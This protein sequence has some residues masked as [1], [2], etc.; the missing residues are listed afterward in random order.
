MENIEED[1]FEQIFENNTILCKIIHP[2]L[3]NKIFE[4]PLTIPQEVLISRINKLTKK[5]IENRQFIEFF[6]EINGK[7]I[8]FILFEI[9]FNSSLN[10]ELQNSILKLIH[11]L[12]FHIELNKEIFEYLFNKLSLIYRK[13][14]KPNPK[15]IQLIL[16]ILNELFFTSDEISLNPKNYFYFTGDGN[17]TIKPN[18]KNNKLIINYGITI[19][20]NFKVGLKVEEFNEDYTAQLLK[21]TFDSKEEFSINLKYPFVLTVDGINQ[22]PYRL[23]NHEDWNN[24]VINLGFDNKKKNCISIIVNGE[25]SINTHSFN[26]MFYNSSSEITNMVFFD[27]FVGET[28]S[29]IF[30]SQ[31]E[32]GVS[33]IFDNFFL[34]SFK[35]NYEG[36]WK[37]SRI[38]NFLKVINEQTSIKGKKTNDP[39]KIP[40]YLIDDLKFIITPFNCKKTIRPITKNSIN[41]IEDSLSNYNGYYN[42]IV[43][44]HQYQCYQ[45]KINLLFGIENLFPIA[46]MFLTISNLLNEENLKLYFSLFKKILKGRKKNLIIAHQNKCF[47]ILSLFFE[48]Y[49][50]HF[51]TKGLVEEISNIGKLLLIENQDELT[52]SYFENI[53]LNEKIIS[54]FSQDSQITLWDNI[55]LCLFSDSSE[56]GKIFNMKKMCIILRYYDERRYDKM[57]C[58]IHYSQFKEDYAGDK[59]IMNPTMPQRLLKMNKIFDFI[60]SNQ[61][62]ESVID[63][64]H[65]LTLDISPCLTKFILKVFIKAFEKDIFSEYQKKVSERQKQ[66]LEKNKNSNYELITSVEDLKKNVEEERKR[67]SL[68]I[69]NLESCN[70]YQILIG[71]FK[72]GLFDIRLDIIKLLFYIYINYINIT[73]NKPNNSF[74]EMLK[75]NLLPGEIFYITNKYLDKNEDEIKELAAHCTVKLNKNNSNHIKNNLCN[76]FN[77]KVCV[78]DEVELETY[79]VT[80]YN[81]LFF[82]TIK[83]YENIF[84]E[85]TIEQI[86][87]ENKIIY[88]PDILQLILYFCDELNKLD[89]TF[90]LIRKLSLLILC[91]NNNKI[92]LNNNSICFWLLDKMFE[93]FENKNELPKLIFKETENL[94]IKIFLN[95]LNKATN[96]ENPAIKLE[97]ILIWGSN[98]KNL[99]K[100]DTQIFNFIRFILYDIYERMY[101]IEGANIFEYKNKL[102]E[103]NIDTNSFLRNYL[104][105]TTLIFQFSYI[106]KY[107]NDDIRKNKDMYLEELSNQIFLPTLFQT[108]ISLNEET[109]GNNKDFL[110][111]D[112]IFFQSS[113][114]IFS[115]I[116]SKENMYKVNPSLLQNKSKD[117]FTKYE[118]ILSTIILNKEKKNYYMQD[119][120]FLCYNIEIDKN[121]L[122]MIPLLSIIPIQLMTI[123]SLLINGPEDEYLKYIKE[124]KRFIKFII[125]ASSNAFIKT[126][127]N[128]YNFIMDKCI[129]TISIGICFIEKISN[130]TIVKKEETKKCLT[131]LMALCLII[132]RHQ[133][134]YMEK[135]QFLKTILNKITRNNLSLCSVFKLFNTFIVDKENKPILDH[136][137]IRQLAPS[138]FSTIA[139]FLE[140]PELQN[141]FICNNKLKISLKTTYFYLEYLYNTSVTRINLKNQFFNKNQIDIEKDICNIIPDYVAEL[142]KYSNSSY[143]SQKEKKT[144]YQKLKK[145]MFSWNGLWSDKELFYKNANRLKLK[146]INHYTKNFMKPIL[147][148][149]LDLD[150][151]IPNFTHYDINF[152][153]TDDTM[154]NKKDKINLD[155]DQILKIDENSSNNNNNTE[156]NEKE[157]SPIDNYLRHIYKNSNVELAKNYLLISK[158]LD[159]GKDNDEYR[160]SNKNK[161][162]NKEEKNKNYYLCCIVKT[163][164]HIKGVISIESKNRYFQFKVFSNQKFE[165]KK[166]DYVFSIKG[167]DDY[168]PVRK[169][170]YGSFFPY[171]KKDKDLSHI[172]FNFITIKYIFRRRYFYK[173]S[174]LE[175]FTSNNKSYYFNFKK[176]KDRE[177]F[178]SELLES[179]SENC[180]IINDMK[181][182]DQF[183]NIIGYINNEIIKP[184]NRKKKLKLSKKVKEWSNWE[185]SNFELLMWLNILSNRSLNDISQYPIFPWILSNFTDPLQ[186]D[187]EEGINKDYLYR[188]LSLPMGMLEVSELSI[189]RKENFIEHYNTMKSEQEETNENEG[190]MKPYVYGTHYSCPN[191]V[192]NY[193]MRL[194]PFSHI[195][196]EL[197][198]KIDKFDEPDRLVYS[199]QKT[200]DSSTSLNTDLRELIPEFYYLPEI[201]INFN[202][203]NMGKLEN[204][205]LVNDIFT[206]C[207][208]DPY[209]FVILMRSILENEIISL[210]IK[211]WIDLIFGFKNRGKDAENCFNIFTEASYED[212]I[213]LNN[214]EDKSCILRLAEFGLTPEQIYNKEFP[215]KIKKD[216]ILKGKEITNEDSNLKIY[217]SK[218][219]QELNLVNSFIIKTKVFEQNN[220][221]IL[222]NNF[223]YFIKKINYSFMDKSFFNDNKSYKISELKLLNKIN[224]FYSFENYKNNH[225]HIFNKGKS[226][227]IGGF[228]DGKIIIITCEPK[229]QYIYLSP[230]NDEIPISSIE[231]NQ[232]EEYALIGNL[233]GNI[234]IYSINFEKK[235]NLLNIISAHSNQIVQINSNDDLNLFTSA[236]IN[237]FINIYTLP[238]CKLTRSIKIDINNCTNIFLSSCPIN[239]VIIVNSLI[240]DTELY[241]YSINGHFLKKQNTSSNIKSPLIMKDLSSNEYFVYINENEINIR[242]IPSFFM[243]VQIDLNNYCINE[244]EIIQSICI[245]ED[246][247][248]LYAINSNG[249]HVLIIKG[250]SDDYVQRSN[251]IVGNRMTGNL[252]NRSIIS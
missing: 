252:V 32:N 155:I 116:F 207:E 236:T 147:M 181:E 81:T 180:K 215:Q 16:Q 108:G 124:Y 133:Y 30:F 240:D 170:C 60:F 196:I 13:I 26:K 149:I 126:Q 127:E 109:I 27:K 162:N 216:V 86:Q 229:I 247:N 248:N 204:G 120:K 129:Q 33:G 200:F 4:N 23:I 105:I 38:D 3:I 65:L 125:I 36:I 93:N 49:P 106:F 117:Y 175:I 61:E 68:I 85:E 50:N 87:L 90:S 54:K 141:S 171:H 112:F 5:L 67:L 197:N 69:K 152:M 168:D 250:K 163:S 187:L 190:I 53:F 166:S 159:L 111:K 209:E 79:K 134:Q 224:D 185:I 96:Y 37:K 99:Y 100:D 233:I 104:F 6:S 80:L 225:I 22:N 29:I 70:Y 64:F 244:K 161:S 136:D 9:I 24:M 186:K 202:K 188:D 40:K 178:L 91:D 47:Q 2:E 164:H 39:K 241:A 55:I 102:F 71:V 110:W 228:Y 212:K 12:S 82:W 19:I 135:G 234:A 122:K 232:N 176:E 174:A 148:P 73:G 115:Y 95:S 154:K 88:Y 208:N 220:I 139:S 169:A 46:E 51:F 237:G 62:V 221:S 153:F 144:K 238:E 138:H 14:D 131:H 76:S 167:N 83:D 94:Y 44:N 242:T 227:I 205:Y 121:H 172:N 25:N 97:N 146:I 130:M 20:L 72:K 101:M 199:V 119:L 219:K 249:N 84:K 66:N 58:N 8:Y 211:N 231:I 206:P 114:K 31:V 157:I 184:E 89:F 218:N 107:E 230:F 17:L 34:S 63:L 245:S 213:N 191:Y 92:L 52:R 7:S 143:E 15:I 123:I 35:N 156:I 132:V 43:I 103:I 151:Y 45:K 10:E 11:E 98:K 226:I 182:K 223:Q 113:Y 118:T 142:E 41:E 222:T 59:L 18:N 193:L 177:N 137:K 239:C 179:I 189:I 195:L 75:G 217:K 165:N 194:F 74:I 77:D 150:Y 210:N 78:L 192:T 21:F 203:L 42:G 160:P 128:I 140:K 198:G 246:M 201:F 251:T 173:N 145:K 1:I 57:C 243:Q 158:T 28:T 48:K 214:Y 183:D 56:I 235:F